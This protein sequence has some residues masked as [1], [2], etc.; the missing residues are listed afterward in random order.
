[1]QSTHCAAHVIH[2]VSCKLQSSSKDRHLRQFCLYCFAAIEKSKTLKEASKIYRCLCQALSAEVDPEEDS[3]SSVK[4]AVFVLK[5]AISKSEDNVP[6]NTDA[7]EGI[8][9]EDKG[10]KAGS[11]IKEK[12][13]FYHQFEKIRRKVEN[14]EQEDQGTQRNPYYSPQAL[15][16]VTDLTHLYPLWSG[17]LLPEDK[18]RDTNS[19]TELWMRIAKKR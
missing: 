3:E 16:V 6:A 5:S 11:S 1:M 12:S 18:S 14:S 13:A 9:S 10:F 7:N 8:N 17:L 15:K 19:P 4:S 2:L